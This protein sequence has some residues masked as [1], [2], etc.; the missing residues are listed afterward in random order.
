MREL[1]PVQRKLLADLALAALEWNVGQRNV[2][3]QVKPFEQAGVMN[4]SVPPTPTPSCD[5]SYDTPL[6]ERLSG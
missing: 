6:Y 3:D 4:R 1:H 5:W 2:I